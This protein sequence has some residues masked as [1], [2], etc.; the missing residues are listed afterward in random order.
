MV[1]DTEPLSAVAVLPQWQTWGL[2]MDYIT[3]S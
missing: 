3:G 1:T 2:T